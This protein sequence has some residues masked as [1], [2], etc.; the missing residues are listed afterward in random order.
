MI[1]LIKD[2]FFY[3]SCWPVLYIWRLT[4]QSFCLDQTR[5]TKEACWY[6]AEGNFID[7]FLKITHYKVF[8]LT[9]ME[10]LLHL[11]DAHELSPPPP[12]PP[13]PQP[14]PPPPRTTPTYHVDGTT[15]FMYRNCS[16][17]WQRFCYSRFVMWENNILNRWENAIIP[18]W[19]TT[20]IWSFAICLCYPVWYRFIW[21][22][23]FVIA[24]HWF[25]KLIGHAHICTYKQVFLSKNTVLCILRLVPAMVLLQ[26][27][28]SVFIFLD[29]TC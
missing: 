24:F 20:N 26:Q 29:N 3:S 14:H 21:N 23:L 22:N 4:A 8:V 6:L 15:A 12:P 19:M 28:C 1:L 11:K 27:K 5:S 18:V 2:R 7:T 16:K 17:L 13:T 25:D 10:M 9:Y